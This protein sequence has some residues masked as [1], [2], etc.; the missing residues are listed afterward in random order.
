MG[1]VVVIEDM[2]SNRRLET[3]Q[4]SHY[5]LHG[6]YEALPMGAGSFFYKKSNN[7]ALAGQLGFQCFHCFFPALFLI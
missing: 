2:Q 6:V 4:V 1:I 7:L 5:N 3:Q